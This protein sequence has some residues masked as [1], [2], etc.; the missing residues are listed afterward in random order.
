MLPLFSVGTRVA[1]PDIGQGEDKANVKMLECV[2]I[3]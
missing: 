3:S 1:R 2:L